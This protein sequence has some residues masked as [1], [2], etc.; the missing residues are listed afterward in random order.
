MNADLMNRVME[1]RKYQKK[2]IMALFPDSKAG[3]IEVIE[4]ELRAMF[5]EYAVELAGQCMQQKGFSGQ[6]ES[7]GQG[8]ETS[9][10]ASKQV[11][12]HKSKV[13]KVSIDI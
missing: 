2:A 4:K 11:E 6:E 3:H 7:S 1:A 5:M 9:Q 10:D 12:N 8:E 13:R